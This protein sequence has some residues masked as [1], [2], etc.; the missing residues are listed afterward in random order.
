MTAPVQL[1]SFR[2]AGMTFGVDALEVQEI[3]RVAAMTRVPLADASVAGLINLRGQ[4]VT[5]IDLRTRLGLPPRDA[6]ERAINVVIRTDDGVFGLLVDE[7][8]DVLDADRDRLDPIPETVCTAVRD[9]IHGAIK[10]P[11]RLLL[12]LVTDRVVRTEASGVLS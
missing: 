9:V 7:I 11:D 1:C 5:A 8:G 3:I 2:L 4:I 12:V 6:G 10:L